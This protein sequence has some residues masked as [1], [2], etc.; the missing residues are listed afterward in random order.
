MA[1]GR[2]GSL[3]FLNQG[4]MHATVGGGDVSRSDDSHLAKS[5]QT[6]T[7]QEF[8]KI[9]KGADAISS[10]QI[11]QRSSNEH[12]LPQD[13]MALALLKAMSK[14]NPDG[15]VHRTQVS[16]ME[17]EDLCKAAINDLYVPIVELH[18]KQAKH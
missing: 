11:D 16:A 13:R 4:K 12:L 8:S 10:Q 15:K 3:V 9:A 2:D 5:M 7:N 1:A 14:R 18:K 17:D 6:I